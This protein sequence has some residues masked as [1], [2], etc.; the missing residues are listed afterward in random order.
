MGLKNKVV[1]ALDKLKETNYVVNK[2]NIDAVRSKL[3][4]DDIVKIVDEEDTTVVEPK[5]N[6]PVEGKKIED[7][8][9]PIFKIGPYHH[10]YVWALFPEGEA[11]GVE[12]IEKG[13][14]LPFD[15]FKTY[16]L[17]EELSEA[18]DWE[19]NPWAV[20]TAS[21]GRE[22]KDKYEKCVKKVKA[23]QESINPRMSKK[24]LESL[25]ENI[26][27]P[28]VLKRFKKNSLK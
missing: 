24:E 6:V 12:I 14:V 7:I 2:D 20:C 28:I 3:D 16:I 27:T 21:T 22:D 25:V 11:L 18:K 8:G 23:Q 4:K 17:G 13:I 26:D 15:W 19:Y 5:N 1:E 9:E 10:Q